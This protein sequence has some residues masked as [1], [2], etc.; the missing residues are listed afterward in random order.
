MAEV[1]G[2]RLGNK[3]DTSVFAEKRLDFW[4]CRESHPRFWDVELRAHDGE[5]V[6]ASRQDLSVFSPVFQ[7]MFEGDF[8]EAHSDSVNVCINSETLKLLLDSCYEGKVCGLLTTPFV[9]I[10]HQGPSEVRAEKCC[11]KDGLEEDTTS[12]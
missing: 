11:C 9:Y 6:R 12:G 7:K 5:V 8:R 4:R 1:S 3:F 10:H 2:L